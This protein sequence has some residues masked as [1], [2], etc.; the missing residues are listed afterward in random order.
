MARKWIQSASVEISDNGSL[1]TEAPVPSTLPG[2]TKIVTAATTPEKLVTDPTPCRAVWIGAR[3]NAA[4]GAAVNTKAVKFGDADSQ[5]I[6]ILPDDFAGWEWPIDD[7]SKVYV[8]VGTDGEGVEYRI[9]PR[10]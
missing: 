7:A 2:G 1:Q 9:I 6:P 8:R 5:N 10:Q 3:L 4:T